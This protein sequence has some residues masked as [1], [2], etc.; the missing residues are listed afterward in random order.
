[1]VPAGAG[2]PQDAAQA[3]F[4]DRI[5]RGHCTEARV[6]VQDGVRCPADIVEPPPQG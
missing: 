1:M 2:S 5:A 4:R 6:Q 3:A